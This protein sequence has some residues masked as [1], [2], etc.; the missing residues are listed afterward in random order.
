MHLPHLPAGDSQDS[1]DTVMVDACAEAPSTLTQSVALELAT[2][3]VHL[4]LGGDMFRFLSLKTA[5][6]KEHQKPRMHWRYT[7]VSTSTSILAFGVI[8]EPR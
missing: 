5:H 6:V 4:S 7:Y 3:M 1:T 8:T 2:H